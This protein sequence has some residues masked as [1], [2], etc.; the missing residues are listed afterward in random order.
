LS[1]NTTSKSLPLIITSRDSTTTT[2]SLSIISRLK[3]PLP[4]FWEETMTTTK[5]TTRDWGI[6]TTREGS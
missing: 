6:I 1:Q 2:H 5:R 4:A 3:S